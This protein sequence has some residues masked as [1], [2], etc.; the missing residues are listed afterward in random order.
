MSWESGC[1]FHIFN[2][3]TH[4]EMNLTEV[5]VASLCVM[6]SRR[7]DSS[8]LTSL[9]T[10]SSLS[11]AAIYNQQPPHTT[12]WRFKD[13]FTL[14]YFWKLTFANKN[15]K[16]CVYESGFQK[17]LLQETFR[18]VISFTYLQDRQGSKM[19]WTVEDR[20]FSFSSD[21]AVTHCWSLETE[22]CRATG[23]VEIPRQYRR[24]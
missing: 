18:C 20:T 5:I 15:L 3:H 12:L 2:S 6:T 10:F 8:W 11:T 16:K 7:L 21:S 22:V 14:F 9:F 17:R 1:S 19:M 23:R 24:Y 13:S 4:T